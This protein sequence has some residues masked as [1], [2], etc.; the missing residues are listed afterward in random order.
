MAIRR[1]VDTGLWYDPLVSDTFTKDDKLF[2]LYCLTN[3]HNNLCGTAIISPKV[4][5]I[6][7]GIEFELIKP[8]IDKFVN[9]YKR[10]KYNFENNELL[11]LNWYRYN[12]STSLSVKQSLEKQL[13]DIKTQEFKNIVIENMNLIQWTD[14]TNKK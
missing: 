7:S 14:K 10:I 9:E 6:E 5:A 8:I 2:W 11:M 3:P 1:T 12:W 4:I 13:K